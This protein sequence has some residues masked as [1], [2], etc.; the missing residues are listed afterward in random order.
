MRLGGPIFQKTDD[1]AKAVEV[2]RKLGFGAAF[3]TYIEDDA[4]R[5]E[6]V[7]AFAEADIVLAE[8]GSY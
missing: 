8:Y 3:A 1:P 4:R 2:H 5:S 6:F 7:K